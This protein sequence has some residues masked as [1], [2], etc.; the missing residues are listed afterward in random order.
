MPLESDILSYEYS[1]FSMYPTFKPLDKVLIEKCSYKSIQIGDVIVFLTVEGNNKV[2]HRVISNHKLGFITQG[3]NLS[4]SDKEAVKVEQFIGR[5]KYI[6]RGNRKIAVTNGYSGF[7]EFKSR[8]TLSRIREKI[9]NNIFLRSMVG[10]ISKLPFFR[11]ISLNN[12]TRT[13]AVK[14]KS[15]P[16]HLLMLGQRKIGWFEIRDQQWY[17]YPLYRPFIDKAKL[18]VIDSSFT[19]DINP[20]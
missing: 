14:L 5:A 16:E 15:G 7:I 18:P 3:D 17:I 6:F 13:V 8:K 12:M 1:G 9:L 19:T 2:I 10:R 11:I 4:A 20:V